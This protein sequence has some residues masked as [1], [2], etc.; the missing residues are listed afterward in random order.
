MALQKL[1]LMC[2]WFRCCLATNSP[3]L[4]C[5]PS[6]RETTEPSHQQ[7]LCLLCL[8]VERQSHSPKTD[9]ACCHPPHVHRH[10]TP[11]VQL[12][13]I[14]PVCATYVCLLPK[15][16]FSS[17][18]FDRSTLLIKSRGSFLSAFSPE[19]EETDSKA[20]W[21]R[22]CNNSPH[23]PVEPGHTVS[24]HAFQRVVETITCRDSLLLITRGWRHRQE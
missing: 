1:W 15:R 3:E 11:S 4:C 18:F 9:V 24:R 13:N 23:Q 7:P 10:W 22:P 21:L 16:L 20:T 14:V 5:F 2:L 19:L 6:R 17:S 12:Y 8:S